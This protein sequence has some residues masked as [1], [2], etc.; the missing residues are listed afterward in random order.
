MTICAASLG[1]RRCCSR[2]AWQRRTQPPFPPASGGALNGDRSLRLRERFPRQ[3]F[4]SW[5]VITSVAVPVPLAL[6]A[7][8]VTFVVPAE[9]GLPLISPDPAFKVSPAGRLVAL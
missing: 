1:F 5:I 3:C 8:I 4:L 7:P 6:V 9:L 2:S